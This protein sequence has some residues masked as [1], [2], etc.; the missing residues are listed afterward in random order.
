[1][2]LISSKGNSFCF[3]RIRQLDKFH[4]VIL[5]EIENFEKDSHSLK[6]MEKE[7]LVCIL[8]TLSCGKVSF[9]EIYRLLIG[10][11]CY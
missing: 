10:S 2:Q 1:M 4:F 5:E 9:Y 7:F 6:N 3:G 8:F 11:L